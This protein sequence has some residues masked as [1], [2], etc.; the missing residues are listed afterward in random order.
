MNEYFSRIITQKKK[1]IVIKTENSLRLPTAHRGHNVCDT[2]A[3]LFYYKDEEP[4]IT[5]KKGSSS[6]T[7]NSQRI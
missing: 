2:G 7:Y 3:K 4:I 1:R 5:K 6:N